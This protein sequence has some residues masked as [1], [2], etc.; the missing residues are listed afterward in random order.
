MMACPDSQI[1]QYLTDTLGTIRESKELQKAV[2]M[3]RGL[4]AF[5][6]RFQKVQDPAAWDENCWLLVDHC[7]AELSNPGKLEIDGQA[8]SST[9][10]AGTGDSSKEKR[11]FL[12]F[13]TWRCA[14][15]SDWDTSTY[16]CWGFGMVIWCGALITATIF[17][18]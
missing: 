7:V 13:S 1:K 18:F 16:I 6:N 17:T 10:A 12:D 5:Y 3:D 11:S 8:A 9:A 4:V 2:N 15:P 14:A